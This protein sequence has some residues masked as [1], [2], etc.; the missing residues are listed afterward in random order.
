[1]LKNSGKEQRIKDDAGR[2]ASRKNR[3]ELTGSHTNL[4]TMMPSVRNK[5]M[6]SLGIPEGQ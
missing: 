3:T 1:M 5:K 4:W 6:A 2:R